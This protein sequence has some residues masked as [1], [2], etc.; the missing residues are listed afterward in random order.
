MRL[1]FQIYDFITIL[2]PGIFLMLIV[3]IEY[4]SLILWSIENQFGQITFLFALAFIAG[5]VL[6]ELAK[7]RIMKILINLFRKKNNGENYSSSTVIIGRNDNIQV[8]KAFSNE[9][10]ASFME[11][12]NI[13]PSRLSKDELFTLIYSPVHDRMGQRYVFSAIANFHRSMASV[14]IIYLVYLVFKTFYLIFHPD[15]CLLIPETIV[16]FTVLLISL[17]TFVNGNNFFNKLS[18]QIPYYAFLSWY[19]ENKMN[20]KVK[21]KISTETDN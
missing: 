1:P 12:Y 6:H 18:D 2:F 13:D 9:F 10:N 21:D 15:M 8:S 20:D 4:P 14:T 3:R 7:V 17:Y 16:W 19:K 11:F 5:H